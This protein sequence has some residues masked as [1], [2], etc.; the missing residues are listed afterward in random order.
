MELTRLQEESH[1]TITSVDSGKALD[2]V[3]CLSIFLKSPQHIRNK[4]QLP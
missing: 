1:I 2:N 3:Q 4:I